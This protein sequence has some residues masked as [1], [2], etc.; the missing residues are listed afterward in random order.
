MLYIGP[1]ADCSF[2]AWA[3]DCCGVG[4][5]VEIGGLDYLEAYSK[6]LDN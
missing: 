6:S 2:K 1:W 3:F 4:L 5:R